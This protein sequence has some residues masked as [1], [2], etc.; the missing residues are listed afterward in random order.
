MGWIYNMAV[1]LHWCSR[2]H[3]ALSNANSNPVWRRNRLFSGDPRQVFQLLKLD[4]SSRMLMHPSKYFRFTEIF[5]LYDFPNIFYWQ[6]SELTPNIDADAVP[7]L[8][9]HFAFDGGHI[10]RSKEGGV[11]LCSLNAHKSDGRRF[12]SV[13][14]HHHET[15]YLSVDWLRTLELLRPEIQSLIE[16]TRLADRI[17]RAKWQPTESQTLKR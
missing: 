1:L 16:L 2:L 3:K 17:Y 13:I 6:P 14:F 15:N 7:F 11:T 8:N 9:I 4:H 5:G 12:C 10:S